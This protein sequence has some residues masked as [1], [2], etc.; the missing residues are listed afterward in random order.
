VNPDRFT[1]KISLRALLPWEPLQVITKEQL[2]EVMEEFGFRSN[3]HGWII[4][5][6]GL[7]TDLAS[8]PPAIHAYLDAKAKTILGPCLPHDFIYGLRGILPD[9]RTLTRGDGDDVLHEACL[10]AGMRPSQAWVVRRMV[11]MFGGGRFAA[12]EI[13]NDTK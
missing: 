3:K 6:V 8:I 5:P 9:G 11:G 13:G 12:T 4:V 7:I 1:G 2:F 10:C